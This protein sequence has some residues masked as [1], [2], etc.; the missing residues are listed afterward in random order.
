M[1]RFFNNDL[2]TGCKFDLGQNPS[3]KKRY[4][5]TKASFLS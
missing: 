2:A 4:A 3:R 1:L 5:V